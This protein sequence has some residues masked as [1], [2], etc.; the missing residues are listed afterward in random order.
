MTSPIII[1]LK[2]TLWKTSHLQKNL[3][4]VKLSTNKIY[5]LVIGITNFI[6]QKISCNDFASMIWYS[7]TFVSISNLD[8]T[9]ICLLAVNAE[10]LVMNPVV[11][12][13]SNNTWSL[14]HQS[15]TE[16]CMRNV[17]IWRIQKY[18]KRKFMSEP[19]KERQV[20]YIERLDLVISD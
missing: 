2:K 7:D 8:S 14:R 18:I 4:Y 13:M 19:F 17:T 16:Y 6:W 5:S 12:K 15:P 1:L 9:R 11:Y 3:A 20:R 10:L